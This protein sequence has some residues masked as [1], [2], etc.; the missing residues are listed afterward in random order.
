MAQN[1]RMTPMFVLYRLRFLL[2]GLVTS[3]LIVGVFTTV[4]STGAKA[5]DSPTATPE[6]VGMSSE[7]LKRLD[8]GSTPTSIAAAHQ[9]S[10]R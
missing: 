2:I 3:V 6:Q 8:M 7:R 5:D 1:E 9:V 4:E 10:S